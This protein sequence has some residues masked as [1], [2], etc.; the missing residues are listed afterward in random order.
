M[1]SDRKAAKVNFERALAHSRSIGMREGVVE[2]EDALARL[3]APKD[4]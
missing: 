1:E 2:A 3:S 4:V